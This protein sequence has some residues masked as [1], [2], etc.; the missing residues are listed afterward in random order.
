VVR[1][2]F[3]SGFCV[4]YVGIILLLV[5]FRFKFGGLLCGLVFCCVALPLDLWVLL[6]FGVFWGLGRI[7]RF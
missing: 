5:A 3:F 6:L 2:L 7:L 4:T 1:L